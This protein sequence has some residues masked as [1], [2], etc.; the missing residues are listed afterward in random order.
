MSNAQT[1]SIGR[2]LLAGLAATIA[3][4]LT[5]LLKQALGVM[6]QLNLVLELARALGYDRVSVGW[7]ANFV[8]G[9]LCWGTLFPIVERRMFF[10]HWMNGLLFSSVVWLGVMLIIMPAAGAGLFGMHLGIV[11]PTLTLFL[12]WVYGAVLGAVYGMLLKPTIGAR[13]MQ[14]LHLHHA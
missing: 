11:T 8:V 7:T 13:A 1:A 6:P 9:V 3:L 14:L 12:H 2:G 10:A 4:S 5:L